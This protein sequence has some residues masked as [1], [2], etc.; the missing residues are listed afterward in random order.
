M[1]VSTVHTNRLL[2]KCLI[3]SMALH[4]ALL[5]FFYFNPFILKGSLKS[6]F[7]LSSATPTF[8]DDDTD[9]DAVLKNREIEEVFKKIIVMSSHFQQPYDFAEIPQG[10]SLAPNAES[11]FAAV[12]SQIHE[13]LQTSDYRSPVELVARRFEEEDF[14]DAPFFTPIETEAPIASQLQIDIP[15]DVPEI[16]SIHVSMVGDGEYEDLVALNDYSLNADYEADYAVN[17]TPQLIAPNQILKD[18]EIK[19]DTRPMSGC[20]TAK[21]FKLENEP[22]RAKLFIPKSSPLLLEKKE[23]A[24]SH[25]NSELEDYAFPPQSQATQWNDDFDVDVVFL[26]NPEGKG[27]I[28]SLS[29]KPNYDISSQSL[30]QNL[31]FVLD[32]SSSVQKHRFTVFKRAVLKALA[33]MQ[34]GDTFNILVIDKK[35]ARFSETN[36]KVSM[37]SI[38]SAE[39]FLDKQEG[40]GL[41]NSS[42]IYVNLD[43]ILDAVP[44]NDEMHTAIL[45]TDGKSN[46]NAERRQAVMKKWIEKNHGKLSLY[47][48]AV[49][50]DNDLVSLD[51]LSSLSGG[52]LLYSDT[53]ASMPRKL[54]KLILDLQDPVA[55]DMIITAMPENP[56]SHITLSTPHAQLPTLY[57][58]QPYVVFGQIDDPCTFDLVIQGRHHDQWIAIK[59]NISFIEGKKGDRSLASEWMAQHS[60]L[61]YAKFLQEG[62]KANLAE[63]REVLKKFRTEV[64]FE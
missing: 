61:I 23:I 35:V 2:V 51:M 33:S 54:A 60:H 50:R 28:F 43:Q 58:H 31:Y 26:P 64:A 11:A 52:R 41:F 56:Q 48:A 29:I 24:F 32:R 40:G 4:L 39:E 14:I 42:D 44:D 45:L 12:P 38:Q 6:L 16:A 19:A 10:I 47:A 25:R 57:S 30:K 17:L 9:K 20:I 8:L 27:Y 36:Q 55:K 53:H 21:D 22:S 5:T 62:K 59:K 63:A 1:N 37:K 7:G 49:G 46:L 15:A 13:E 18:L 34:K 3:F